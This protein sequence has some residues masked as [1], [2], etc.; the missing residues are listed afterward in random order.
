MI[1]LTE[2][3]G[4]KKNMKAVPLCFEIKMMLG[5]KGRRL[6]SRMLETTV[7]HRKK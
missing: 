7:Y 4:E 6:I 5:S 1:A 3:E 2:E